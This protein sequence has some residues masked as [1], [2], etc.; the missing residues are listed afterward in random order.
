ML[1]NFFRARTPQDFNDAKTLFL[2]YA[3]WLQVDLCFQEFDKELA[4]IAQLYDDPTGGIFL[5][6]TGGKI[7][8][9]V[10]VKSLKMAV[11]TENAVCEL[12]RMYVREG[13]RRNGFGKIFLEL[14]VE[15]AVKLGYETMRLDTL[16]RLKAAI[17]LYEA[18]GFVEIAPY[19][20]NPLSEVRY[21]EKKLDPSVF[22]NKSLVINVLEDGKDG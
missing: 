21:F 8:G 20:Q 14:A 22:L 11:E 3:E 16:N 6:E 4:D 5:M 2:E 10:G 17:A 15:L 1:Y 12:K 13:H 18:S 7:V 9:C 19:Y